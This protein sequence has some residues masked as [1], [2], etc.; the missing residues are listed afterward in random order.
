MGSWEQAVLELLQENGC[1]PWRE[2]EL[3]CASLRGQGG[4]YDLY[5]LVK[6]QM[7][8]SV[9]RWP[10]EVPDERQM[11][12]AHFLHLANFGLLLGCFEL[13]FDQGDLRYR[14]CL[15]QP[16]PP[17]LKE[18]LRRYLFT[19]ALM[20]ERYAPGIQADAPWPYARGKNEGRNWQGM[21]DELGQSHRPFVTGRHVFLASRALT[22]YAKVVTIRLRLE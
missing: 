5:L 8:V 2:G 3:I 15:Y 9:A 21:A 14:C 22:V 13:D 12:M 17:P 6:Q 18:A 20:L 19:P 1:K 4:E 16:G 7:L 10:K 11:E